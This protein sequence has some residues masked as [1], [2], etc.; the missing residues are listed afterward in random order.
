MSRNVRL[1]KTHNRRVREPGTRRGG[2]LETLKPGTEITVSDREF[3]AF[4]DRFIDLGPADGSPAPAPKG[5]ELE[6]LRARAKALGVKGAGRLGEARLREEIAAAEAAKGGAGSGDG[7][8]L[9]QLRAE[10]V[11]L[12]IEISEEMTAEQLQAEIEQ[13]SAGE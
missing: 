7:P 1:R 10:A 8:S 5:D 4:R 13:A 9:E 6:A 3:K 12:G 11:E 2:R